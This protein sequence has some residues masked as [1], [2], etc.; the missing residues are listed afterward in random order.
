MR[1]TGRDALDS[2]GFETCQ[3]T[4]ISSIHT[5]LL[6]NP[7]WIKKPA[8]F[9][10]YSADSLVRAQRDSLGTIICSFSVTEHEQEI[11]GEVLSHISHFTNRTRV[12]QNFLLRRY[13]AQHRVS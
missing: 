5:E 1:S 7:N 3:P 9:F 4:P 10:I 12:I 2:R 6:R 13:I 11:G 8:G